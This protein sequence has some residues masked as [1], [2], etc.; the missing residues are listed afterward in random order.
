MGASTLLGRGVCRALLITK[1]E[2][3]KPLQV[4]TKV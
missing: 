1:V 4:G 2:M 3:D